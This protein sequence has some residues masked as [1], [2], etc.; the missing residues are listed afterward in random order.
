MGKGHQF[1][2]WLLGFMDQVLRLLRFAIHNLCYDLV[3]FGVTEMRAK[4]FCLFHYFPFLF[5]YLDMFFS[6]HMTS[7]K[8]FNV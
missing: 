3:L 6:C 4:H 1:I 2:V 7:K 8:L 5:L